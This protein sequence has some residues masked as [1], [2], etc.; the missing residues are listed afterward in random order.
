MQVSSILQDDR[1]DIWLATSGGLDHVTKEGFVSHLSDPANPRSLS[2]DIVFD[3]FQDAGGVMWVATFG[4]LNYWSRSEY[5]AEHVSANQRIA[6][7]LSSSAVTAISESS[8]GTVWVGTFGGSLN[9]ILPNGTIRHH[10]AD[11]DD[12]AS[13]PEDTVMSLFVDSKERI[14]AQTPL[15]QCKAMAAY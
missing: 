8:D 13:I 12:P 2:N 7:S 4:G 15:T 3:L 6:N 1:G 9:E 14:W 10:R 5:L 11:V